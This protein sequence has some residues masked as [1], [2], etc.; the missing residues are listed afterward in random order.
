MVMAVDAMPKWQK[1]Y[2]LPGHI[3]LE[4]VHDDGGRKLASLGV[5]LKRFLQR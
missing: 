1:G 2:D 3:P 4:V 5:L